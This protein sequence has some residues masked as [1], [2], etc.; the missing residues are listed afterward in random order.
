MSKSCKVLALTV[1]DLAGLFGAE[2]GE[3]ISF[4]KSQLEGMD[5][6]YRT[7]KTEER[8]HVLLQVLA[9]IESQ[10]LEIAGEARLPAWERGW[11][12]NL[13][14]FI[15][16]GYN[17][18]KLVPKYYK[19]AAIVR[20]NRDYV[21][22]IGDNF[23]LN[24]TKIFRSWIFSK[25]LKTAECVHEFG[26]GPAY[27]LA[28]LAELNGRRKLFGYDWTVASQRIIGLLKNHYGYQME[29][30]NFD[31]FNPNNSLELGT[32]SAVIT[33]GALEQ[34]GERHE[35]FLQF[36]LEKR[37]GICINIECIDEYYDER[38]LLDYL[39]YRYHRKRNYLSGY[40]TRLQ[41]LEQ[42][43]RIEIIKTYHQMFGNIFGDPH[44]YIV[45]KP[46]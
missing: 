10:N 23:V 45:W 36:L 44:S 2:E 24:V 30:T 46:K 15:D 38:H 41:Q 25:Y 5:L 21:M 32:D 22:P 42:A 35:K 14:D 29:G 34:V 16:S 37:P 13:T 12:E 18:E 1:S 17:I 11:N 9:A 40:L 39:A 33:F 28:Y 6:R 4:C 20:L 19:K 3:L 31:F 26:C 27:H 7:L 8:D 43:G